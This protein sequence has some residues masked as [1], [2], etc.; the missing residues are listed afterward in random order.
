MAIT[1]H[2]VA[3]I[4]ALREAARSTDDLFEVLSNAH[5]RFVVSCLAT[6][7]NPLAVADFATELACW[8]CKTPSDHISAEQVES[9]YINLY[10]VHIPKMADAGILRYNQ[11][12]D[13]IALADE[14]DGITSFEAY[15]PSDSPAVHTGCEANHTE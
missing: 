12:Q 15:S 13:T 4:A 6:H 8:E 3:D 5:R 2:S 14:C 1:E 10:H 11:E 9:R 7:P